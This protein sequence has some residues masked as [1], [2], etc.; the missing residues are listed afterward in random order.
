MKNYV[1]IVTESKGYWQYSIK[2]AIESQLSGW[3]FSTFKDFP[4][5]EGMNEMEKRKEQ[6][7]VGLL[8]EPCRKAED[9]ERFENY[10]PKTALASIRKHGI[11]LT[12]AVFLARTHQSRALHMRINTF[13]SFLNFLKGK[14]FIRSD[15]SVTTF[16]YAEL[17]S[18]VEYSKE[19][20]VSYTSIKSNQEYETCKVPDRRVMENFD[21]VLDNRLSAKEQ[22][23]IR[24][25]Y[26]L[27]D[28]KYTPEEMTEWFGND[29]KTIG[30]RPD[31]IRSRTWLEIQADRIRESRKKALTK[32]GQTHDDKRE[33]VHKLAVGLMK[34]TEIYGHDAKE[35]FDPE[36]IVSY[37][38]DIIRVATL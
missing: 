4:D 12:E 20:A 13:D 3:D 38:Q 30:E 26:G 6:F 14:N 35:E 16:G 32:L 10:I 25:Y 21:L 22:K 24:G 18:L 36:L 5:K 28:K 17:M 11:T 27:D 8:A 19:Y 37:A 1:G 31:V 7:E 9:I 29:E 34:A 2:Q 23:I 33:Y 15:M